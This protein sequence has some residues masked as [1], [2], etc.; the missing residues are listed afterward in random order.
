MG[1]P[2]T[3]EI[4][5]AV[6]AG[7]TGH[8]SPEVLETRWIPLGDAHDLDLAPETRFALEKTRECAAPA[9]DALQSPDGHGTQHL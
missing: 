5:Q 2:D 7:H 3:V 6:A 1:N 4:F 9:A 8:L